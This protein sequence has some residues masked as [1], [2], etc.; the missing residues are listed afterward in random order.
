MVGNGF[1]A[2]I[3]SDRKITGRSAAVFAELVAEVGPLSGERHQGR[4]ASRPR[5]R[6][7]GAGA[8][9]RLVIADRL[10]ATLAH[11]RHETMH[12]V[13]V[14]LP[15]PEFRCARPTQDRGR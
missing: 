14:R 11:L 3:I 15:L 13:L 7:V 6:P 2:A 4:R 5:K 1:R 10:L 12:D 9:H 8:K